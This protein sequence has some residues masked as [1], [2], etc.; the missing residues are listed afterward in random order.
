MFEGDIVY[1]QGQGTYRSER[2]Q[3][4]ATHGGA[5]YLVLQEV[6][7]A[8]WMSLSNDLCAHV[9]DASG[10]MAPLVTGLML[11]HSLPWN[12]GYC[13]IWPYERLLRL[14]PRMCHMKH[15]RLYLDKEQLPER[16]RHKEELQLHFDRLMSAS[17]EVLELSVGCSL[18]VFIEIG[19]KL[20]VLVVA[21]TGW[22]LLFD[23][24]PEADLKARCKLPMKKLCQPPMNRLKQMYL[25]SRA[26]FSPIYKTALKGAHVREAW[27]GVR[28]LDYVGE[29]KDCWTVQVPVNLNLA[30]CR[31]VAVG[32]VLSALRELVCL[33]CV[34]RH[35]QA[36]ALISIWDPINASK[37]LWP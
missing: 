27:A 18:A 10:A 9:H 4:P 12:P 35:G 21:A 36:M 26:A 22:L 13:S 30:A 31:S 17:L 20:D 25:H 32:H 3:I 24:C 8:S 34:I 16:Y 37:T 5:G 11:R 14:A 29:E 23:S 19:L 6:S 2:L 28:L 15:L 33:S 7:L 1:C